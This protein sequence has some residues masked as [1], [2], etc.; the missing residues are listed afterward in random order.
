MDEIHES[1]KVCRWKEAL[2]FQKIS[3]RIT[4]RM[5]RARPKIRNLLK[6]WLS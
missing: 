3:L 6:R 1:K 2:R 5:S 4:A